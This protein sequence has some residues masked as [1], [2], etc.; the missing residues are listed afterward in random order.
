MA[1]EVD[2][3]QNSLS[4][5][6][7]W[8]SILRLDSTARRFELLPLTEATA[9]QNYCRAINPRSLLTPEEFISMIGNLLID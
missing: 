9:R 7:I 3:V 2:K 6:A 8:C 5:V 4:I 1:N